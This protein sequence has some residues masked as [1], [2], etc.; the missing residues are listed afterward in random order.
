MPNSL[1]A[2]VVVPNMPLDELT[3]SFE[4]EKTGALSAGDLISVPLRK[5][6]VTGV[7]FRVRPECEISAAQV[8][9]VSRVLTRQVVSEEMLKLVRWAAD[10]YLCHL[11]QVLELVIPGFITR[12]RKWQ[13]D[14]ETEPRAKEGGSCPVRMDSLDGFQVLVSGV[15]DNLNKLLLPFIT[16]QLNFGSVIVLVPEP[17]LEQLLLLLRSQFG[18]AVIEYSHRL[19]PGHLRRVWEQIVSGGDRVVVGVRSAVWLPVNRL[20][21]V[22]LINENAPSFKEERMPCYHAREVAIARARLFSCPVFLSASPPALETWWQ[23]KNK[24]FKLIDRL[25]FRVF[26]QNVFVVDMRLHRRTLISPRLVRDL[27]QV[28]TAQRSAVCYINRKGVSGYVVCEDCGT[29]LR[30]PHCQLALMLMEEGRVR[31]RWCNYEAV[32]PERCAGCQGTNFSYRTPGVDMVVRELRRLGIRAAKL[33]GSGP[34]GNSG[35]EADYA[36]VLVGTRSA[37]GKGPAPELVALINFDT[38]FALPDF[39]SRERAF[40]LLVSLLTQGPSRLIIQT[41]RPS[42]PVLDFA[43]RG[44]VAGFLNWELKLRAD[45]GFPPFYRLVAITCAGDEQRVRSGL[46]RFARRLEPAGRVQLLGPVK[47]RRLRRGKPQFRLILKLLPDVQPAEI[48]S[49]ELLKDLPGRVRIDVDP[50]EIV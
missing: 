25:N 34:A 6:M 22:A 39:R 46:A 1:F 45:A 48:V 14:S 49:Q 7:V 23:I 19:K 50:L 43:L 24:R 21:G 38:E 33:T 40:T 27:K 26:R 18:P 47:L 2:E 37:L 30:C 29:V 15:R 44:D 13:L 42:D 10:Y 12:K 36:P 20:G 28:I 31:C 5:K 41:Y 17:G 35:A 3:Y 4:P 9:P 16:E 11:G 32:A 8:Q